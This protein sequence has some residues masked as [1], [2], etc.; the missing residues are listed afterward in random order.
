MADTLKCYFRERDM[1]TYLVVLRLLHIVAG[2]FW[3]GTTFFMV[4]F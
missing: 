3:A 2:V 4:S 1:Q